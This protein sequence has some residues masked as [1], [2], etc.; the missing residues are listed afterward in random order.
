MTVSIFKKKFGIKGSYQ[1]RSGTLLIFISIVPQA[2]VMSTSKLYNAP[3]P[4]VPYFTPKQEPPAGSAVE[5]QADNKSIPTL[6][7]PLR[8]RGI[9]FPN[10]VWVSSRPQK[11]IIVLI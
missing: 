7:Q 10:R 6:F 8:I 2:A 4:N 5:P 9:V 3:A 11:P 1:E